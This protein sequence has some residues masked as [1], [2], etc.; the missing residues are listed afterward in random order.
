[1]KLET[2]TRWA[3]GELVSG[4]PEALVKNVCTDSRTLQ[5]GDLFVALHGENFDGHTFVEEAGR[6]GAMGAVVERVTGQAQPG[7]SIVQVSDTLTALQQIAAKYR[8]SLPL[9]VVAVT[10]SN[11]K[12]STKDFTAAVLGRRFRVVKT[13]GNL[14]NHIGLPLTMLNAS[15]SDQIGI[16]E[17]GMNHAG[18]I[19]PL[20]AMAKPEVGMITNVG[21]AHIEFLGTRDAIA[22]EKGM[23][24]EAVPAD[25]YVVLS[26]GDDYSDFIGRRTRA[27]IILA[28]I[29]HGDV[30]ATDIT[31]HSDGTKFTLRAGE[32]TAAALL[33]TP[34]LHMVQNAILAVAVGRIFGLTLAECAEGLKEAHLTHGRFE[35]KL[36][37]GIRVVDDTYNANPDSVT[38]ALQT[39][40]AL[41]AEG[42]R[43]AVLGKMNELG[44]ESERGHR[45]VGE[46][47]GRL[48]FDCVISVGKEA[49][50]ITESARR[51]GAKRTCEVESTDEATALLRELARAGDIVLVKGSRT[52]RME[53]IV[54]GLER[55]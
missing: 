9:R 52:V 42:S 41:P 3:D 38:A 16:F 6:R 49:H 19:A 39:I 34:G 20:A 22:Q 28:G 18:E 55:P 46:T 17:L 54:E 43:I 8:L 11:G 10:G 13:Q 5:K 50:L 32:E 30:R 7:F 44:A 40:A 25:G 31:Q 51:S 45:S 37:R 27:K 12:T 2:I 47:A 15:S 1:M 23:L 26:A 33:A 29:E 53:K 35:Q 21:L 48:G 24:A 4:D 14:N 36:I